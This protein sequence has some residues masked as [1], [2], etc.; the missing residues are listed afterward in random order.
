MHGLRSHPGGSVV[1]A[2]VAPVYGVD[3]KGLCPGGAHS[4]CG[5]CAQPGSP[6]PEFQGL[7]GAKFCPLCGWHRDHHVARG[8]PDGCRTLYPSG[9][10]VHVKPGCRCRR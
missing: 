5:L 6:C 2:V 1:T 7:D 10:W 9:V 4:P 8:W 3:Y